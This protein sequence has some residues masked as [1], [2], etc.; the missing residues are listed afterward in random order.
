MS[1]HAGGPDPFRGI[2]G[3]AMA[4]DSTPPGTPADAPPEAECP[5]MTAFWLAAIGAW[6]LLAT[7]VVVD[8]TG[9]GTGPTIARH[10]LLGVS[11]L[12]GIAA[13]VLLFRGAGRARLSAALAATAAAVLLPV[14]PVV[15]FLTATLLAKAIIAVG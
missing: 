14:M 4:A 8:L 6:V 7:A 13:V 11:A 10:A 3:A 5:P 2:L 15:N 1:R 12:G 9:E